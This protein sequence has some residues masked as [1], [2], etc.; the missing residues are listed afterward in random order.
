M[1]DDE[2]N[3]ID[4]FGFKPV[5]DAAPEGEEQPLLKPVSQV[6]R[7]SIQTSVDVAMEPPEEIAF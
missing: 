3:Q 2:L 4:M 7:R 6:E 1:D 5:A